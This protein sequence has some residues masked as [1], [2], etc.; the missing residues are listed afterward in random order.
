VI[1]L[2]IWTFSRRAF[3][4]T[5]AKLVAPLVRTL[6]GLPINVLSALSFLLAKQNLFK[7]G[8]D[9]YELIF[10]QAGN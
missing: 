3:A 8:I 5:S 9:G 6:P 1:A 2:L 4:L 7:N 10:E